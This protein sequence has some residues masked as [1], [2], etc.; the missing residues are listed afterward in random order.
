MG[1]ISGMDI[2]SKRR[3][4]GKDSS[5]ITSKSKHLSLLICVS[6]ETM[7]EIYTTGG[8]SQGGSLFLTEL[9]MSTNAT[10]KS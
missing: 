10:I 2:E 6:I 9:G 3:K 7:M 1:L 8:P 4:G 5:G